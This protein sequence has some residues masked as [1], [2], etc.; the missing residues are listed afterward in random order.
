MKH[1]SLGILNTEENTIIIIWAYEWIN[2]HT[3]YDVSEMIY[4]IIEKIP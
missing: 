3:F 1:R 2:T 4:D